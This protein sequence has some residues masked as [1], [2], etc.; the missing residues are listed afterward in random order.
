[1]ISRISAILALCA[2]PVFAE[3]HTAALTED[4]TLVLSCLER[5]EAAEQPSEWSQCLDL[6]F[7]PCAQESVGSEPHLTC[8]AEQ[9][10]T[11]LAVS[12]DLE[13]AVKETVTPKGVADLTEL[14]D[15]WADYVVQKCQT[16]AESKAGISAQAAQL[17]CEVTE[18]VGLSGEYAACLEGRSEAQY[19][20][21]PE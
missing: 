7:A 13:T 9:R 10:V 15:F 6:I 8:L 3:S 12:E 14:L 19:C 11:W 4:Q 2:G 1:M 20:V 17:G 18:I 5:L 16:V 21:L